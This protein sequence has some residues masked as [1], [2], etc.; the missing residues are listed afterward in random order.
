[1]IRFLLNVLWLILGSGIALA[2]AYAVAG[3]ICMVLVVTIPSEWRH[4]SWPT[5][6]CG[7]PAAP[8]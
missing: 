8:W 7:R 2:I 4:S 6:R 5:S 1:M 3:P